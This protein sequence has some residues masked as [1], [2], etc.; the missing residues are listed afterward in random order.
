[1]GAANTTKVLSAEQLDKK[2]FVESE[3]TEML[4]AATH[5][6]VTSLEYDARGHFEVVHVTTCPGLFKRDTFGVD[7]TADSLWAIAKDVMRAAAERFE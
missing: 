3:L 4:A 7:V 5:G 2:S 1:M 6:F